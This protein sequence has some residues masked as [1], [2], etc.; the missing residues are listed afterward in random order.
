MIAW[1]DGHL[2]EESVP[3]HLVGP[4]FRCGMGVFETIL[5]HGHQL[6]RF[7]RHI[8][9]LVSSLEAFG[10]PHELPGEAQLRGIVLDVALANGLAGET[11]RVNL[12]SFQNLPGAKASLCVTVM[13]YA[14]DS[15]AVRKLTVYP[16]IHTSYLC[17]HKT[18]ANLHQRLAWEH[19]QRAGMD[20]AVLLGADGLVLEAANAALLF[21]DG[22]GFFTSGTPYRLPSL[23]LEA[24]RRVLPVEETEIDLGSLP[25]FKHAYWLN[26]LGGIQPVIQIDEV[27]YEADWETCRPL[28][29]HLLGLDE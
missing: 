1:L 15:E 11:A 19:A 28:L 25:G 9:R 27:R 8:E 3:L 14:I 16:Q 24:A 29:R 12:F 22:H 6:P 20:D 4:A 23:T 2:I 10:I 21:S 17:G 7:E 26:S 18:M 13:A 5:H